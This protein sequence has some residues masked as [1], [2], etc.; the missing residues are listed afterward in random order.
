MRS[1]LFGKYVFIIFCSA[2]IIVFI[3]KNHA[4]PK[5]FERR[6]DDGDKYRRKFKK[7]KRKF[8]EFQELGLHSFS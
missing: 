5:Y 8:K 3:K 2:V 4:V 7:I 1:S 6:S